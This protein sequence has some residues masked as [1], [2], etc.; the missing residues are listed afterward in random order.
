MCDQCALDGLEAQLIELY[1]DKAMDKSGAR[2]INVEGRLGKLFTPVYIQWMRDETNRHTPKAEVVVSMMVVLSHF[3]ASTVASLAANV[4]DPATVMRK[5][6]AQWKQMIDQQVED[7]IKV[8]PQ[9]EEALSSVLNDLGLPPELVALL[10]G[11][12]VTV[13]HGPKK[14]DTTH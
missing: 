6:A 2:G 10:S 13:I 3:L 4:A 1:H 11:K 8:I 12:K 9:V 5:T 7:K 14:G